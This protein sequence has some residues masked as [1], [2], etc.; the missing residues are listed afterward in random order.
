MFRIRNSTDLIAWAWL[1][2]IAALG[3]FAGWLIWQA[4]SFFVSIARKALS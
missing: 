1:G 4:G 3:I 2:A